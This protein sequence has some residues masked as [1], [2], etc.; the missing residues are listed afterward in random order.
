MPPALFTPS[1]FSL[2]VD[3]PRQAAPDTPANWGGIDTRTP[4]PQGLAGHRRFEK[5]MIFGLSD[6]SEHGCQR[7]GQDAGLSSRHTG[8]FDPQWGIVETAVGLI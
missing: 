6:E 1:D 5:E 8:L 7:P 4:A 3:S 2:V